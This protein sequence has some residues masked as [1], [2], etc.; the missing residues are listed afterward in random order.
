[1]FFHQKNIL[2]IGGTG[3]IGQKLLE[4]LL[5][6]RPKKIR[7]FSRDEH[8]QY[9]LQYKVKNNPIVHFMIGDVR[10]YD[11]VVQAMT[12]MDFV[13]H[14]AAMKHVPICEANPYEAVLTNIVGTYNVIQAAKVQQVKK[15]IFTSTDKVIAPTNNYGAT[16]LT[17]ERIITAF[18]VTEGDHPI[19]ACVRFGNVMGSRG[20][21]IPLFKQQ[22]LAGEEITVTDER[23]SRFMMTIHQAA[24]LTIK[25]MK[26]A[27]GGE[28]FILKMPVIRLSD[29][30]EVMKEEI[31]K[32]Y[33]IPINTFQVKE[34]GL[35][36][37]EKLYEELMTYEESL[38]AY[39][40]PDMYV[41]PPNS[42]INMEET[43]AKKATPGTYQS[44]DQPPLEKEELRK[45]LIQENLL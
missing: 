10:N 45:I 18:Q 38:H 8:K 32:K 41:I 37:G 1:M 27:Q 31:S 43:N 16:K 15:V 12:G 14:V 25:A 3:T 42:R 29:L 6:E 28:I 44:K 17:A 11:R 39:E 35:R 23:M 19:I 20:S 5:K 36:P 4:L 2:I 22:M 33:Q 34:I 26:L 9:E 30:V 21:V 40:Y 13:F 7:I 24:S